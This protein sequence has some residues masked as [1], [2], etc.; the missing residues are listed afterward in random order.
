MGVNRRS[1]RLLL[2]TNTELK[3]I[4]APAISG[5]EQ[6]QRRQRQGRHVVGERPE[7]IALDRAQGG[8][9]QTD[10]VRGGPQVTAHQR[11]VRGLDRDVGAGAHG[12]TQVGLGERG[13]VV[14]TVA[15]H[16]HHPTLVLQVLD[17]V[18]LVG[19]QHLGDHLVDPDL[20]G[21]ALC[22]AVVGPGE[23]HG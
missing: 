7:Q 2:T 6:A 23:Q 22:G 18:D 13:R 5:V 3:A 17:H 9:R 1:R 16:R 20:V 10:R 4:A 12:Q 11:Q 19:G 15:D 8:P 14:D 21:D